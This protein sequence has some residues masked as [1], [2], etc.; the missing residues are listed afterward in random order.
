MTDFFTILDVCNLQDEIRYLV[1]GEKNEQ[2]LTYFILQNVF[3][4]SDILGE[5]E[6]TGDSH[7]LHSMYKFPLIFFTCK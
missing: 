1:W 3:T 5:I 2:E 7:I 4:D 6:G